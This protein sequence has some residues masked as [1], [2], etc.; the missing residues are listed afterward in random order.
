M[1]C[2]VGIA[3]LGC[4]TVGSSVVTRLLTDR[5]LIER[6]S[7]VRYEVRGVAVADLEKCRANG[8]TASLLTRDGRTLVDR[9]D[10]DLVIECIGGVGES[11]ELV[12]RALVCGKSVITANKDL[13]A[14][15]GPRLHALAAAHG[16]SLRYEASACGAIPIVGLLGQSLAG[17]RIEAIAGVINGTCNAILSAMEQGAEYTDAL[18]EAQRLGYAEADP[19]SDVDGV[20]AAHK[21]AVLAQLSFDVAVTT[22]RIRHSGISQVSKRDISR[23]AMLG[24]RIRLV[25]AAALDEEGL[26]A[27]VSTVLVAN[28]HPF[29]QISGPENIVR[30]VARD[31]GALIVRGRGAGGAPTGSAVL[32]DVVA[33]L[34]ALADHQQPAH[35]A[36]K[37]VG[38][39]ASLFASLPHHP[40]LPR[41]PIWDD[42]A[43]N[44]RKKVEAVAGA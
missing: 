32:G 8:I 42:A 22:S 17:D 23:A 1:E 41:Y 29:A 33:T 44:S 25:A 26:C 37:P 16:A 40:E 28:D 27:D 38:D 24:Y 35:P 31:A 4:G 7:G 15:Q 12:E 43:L 34:R 19:S 9:A 5:D 11:A 21:L 39:V 18:A 2:I 13:I 10:V 36:L 6:R 20:D 14:T 30:V 3:V